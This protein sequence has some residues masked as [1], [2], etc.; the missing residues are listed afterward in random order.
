MWC[1]SLCIV[2]NNKS[3]VQSAIIITKIYTVH[4]SF[5]VSIKVA[6]I[7]NGVVI[8]LYEDKSTEWHLSSHPLLFSTLCGQ[9]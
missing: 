6:C 4:T 7:Y 9:K 5:L 1:D 8:L 3:E 2:H